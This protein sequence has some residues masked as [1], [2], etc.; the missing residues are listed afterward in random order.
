MQVQPSEFVVQQLRG[1]LNQGR[2]CASTSLGT[3]EAPVDSAP[4]TSYLATDSDVSCLQ[5]HRSLYNVA[6]ITQHASHIVHML[7]HGSNA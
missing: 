7:A 3:V 6:V 4:S 5:P 1:C 2:A